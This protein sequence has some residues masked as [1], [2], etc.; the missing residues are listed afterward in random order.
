MFKSRYVALLL[1]F[2]SATLF[3]PPRA[4]ADDKET[5]EQLLKRYL[6]TSD[7]KALLEYLNKQVLTDADKGE[8]KKLIEQMGD[9]AFKA[10][11]EASRQLVKAGPSALALLREALS[12][13]DREIASRAKRCIEDINSGPGAELPAS[14]VRH[15]VKLNDPKA[16]ETF[17]AIYPGAGTES[18]RSELLSGLT[19]LGLAGK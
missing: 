6:G 5:D 12:N 13:P 9:R 2:V 17:L 4:V 19:T 1:V 8:L 3:A 7:A 14:A 11:Q 10:R 15:L 18:L 16:L